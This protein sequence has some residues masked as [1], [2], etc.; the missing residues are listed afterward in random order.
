M[1]LWSPTAIKLE[2]VFREVLGFNVSMD[3]PRRAVLNTTGAGIKTVKPNRE[4]MDVWSGFEENKPPTGV[5]KL[6]SDLS[7]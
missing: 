1:Q 3:F 4:K 6:G 7:K 5:P 2:S